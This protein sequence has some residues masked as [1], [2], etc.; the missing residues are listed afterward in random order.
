MRSRDCRARWC[1][2]PAAR[3]QGSAADIKLLS[4]KGKELTFAN[5]I[6]PAVYTCRRAW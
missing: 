5:T 1:S 2:I 6:I 3:R 4:A